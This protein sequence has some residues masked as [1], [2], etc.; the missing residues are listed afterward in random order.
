MVRVTCKIQLVEINNI[1]FTE[2]KCNSHDWL[3]HMIHEQPK[4]DASVAS[5]V[6]T[7]LHF[8]YASL[9][10][11]F[12]PDSKLTFS[13]NPSHHSLPHL[14]GRISRS[15]TTISGLSG[16]SGFCFGLLFL[17]LPF[18]FNQ[19]L[20]CTLNPCTFPFFRFFQQVSQLS[21]QSALASY[22][23]S[24]NRMPVIVFSILLTY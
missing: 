22:Y 24:N 23:L 2:A 10:R 7:A 15:F 16:S 21:S 3:V 18:D 11:C 9:H 19:L 1:V 17:S 4:L 13:L 20:D 12:T 8:H 14:S 6:A 5:N